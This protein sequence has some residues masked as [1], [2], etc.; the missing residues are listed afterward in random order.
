LIHRLVLLHPNDVCGHDAE[1]AGIVAFRHVQLVG[2]VLHQF[3]HVIAVL[4]E[5]VHGGLALEGIPIVLGIIDGNRSDFDRLDGAGPH[6]PFGATLDTGP[7]RGPAF[8]SAS[9]RRAAAPP[10]APGAATSTGKTALATAS[11]AASCGR[12]SGKHEGYDA[13]GLL[14]P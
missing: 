6:P 10:K 2:D 1:A 8:A 7:S 9:P 12:F 14:R 5:L 4:P 3:P 11:A 13:N